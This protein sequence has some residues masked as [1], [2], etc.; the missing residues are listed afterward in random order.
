VPPALLIP[1]LLGWGISRIP[2][3]SFHQAGYSVFLLAMATTVAL[4]LVILLC[5]DYLNKLDEERLRS[6]EQ[7]RLALERLDSIISS[8]MDAILALDGQQQIRVFNSE[9]EKIF[10]CSAAEAIG[11][12]ITRFV[13]NPL[14]GI[15]VG[16]EFSPSSA[17]RSAEMPSSA[18]LYG[19]RSNGERFPLEATVA[20]ILVRGEIL[21]TFVIRDITQRLRDEESLLESES[22]FRTMF[23]NAPVG[24]EQVGLDGRLLMANEA[25][26]QM[27]GYSESELVNKTYKDITYSEDRPRE[28]E[29]LSA[30]FR[31]E[32]NYVDLE[33]RYVHKN[34]SLV[35]V[36]LRSSLVVD[37]HDRPIYRISVV[38]DI[39]LR[40]KSED[41]LIRNERLAATGR[42]AAMIAHEIKNPL[43]AMVNMIYLLQPLQ[44]SQTARE[45]VQILENQIQAISR[46]ANQT[47]DAHRSSDRPASFKISKLITELLDFYRSNAA[48]RGVALAG[49]SE[50][51]GAWVGFQ[52]ELRQVISNLLVNAIEATPPGGTVTLH[53]AESLDWKSGSKGFRISVLDTGTGITREHRSRIFEPF[54]TTKGEMGTGL[55][56]WVTSGIVRRAGGSIRVW[57]SALP[58]RTGTCFSFF[59]PISPQGLAS[60]SSTDIS[61]PKTA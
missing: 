8:A 36:S 18:L 7:E 54:F 46:I 31:K 13:P 16:R 41:A 48:K 40:K 39:T 10:G 44:S 26:C 60:A 21:H 4:V 23:Q 19:V 42:L 27:L 24:M 32:R 20:T 25:L 35:W 29:L 3:A 17:E 14:S 2:S 34:G 59:L 12:P 50:S 11:Q 58:G 37:G 49:C 57:S 1:F 33:K 30:M 45:Y 52:G 51:E 9:A 5:A 22:R 47:L 28:D 43:D 55:G 56:L 6:T 38:Q 61:L 53:L 15:G